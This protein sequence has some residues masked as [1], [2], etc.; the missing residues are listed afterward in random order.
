M[1]ES[2]P[3]ALVDSFLPEG[4]PTQVLVRAPGKVNLALRVGPLGD[5]GYHELA[6]VFLALDLVDEL[7]AE[8]A[9]DLS[10]HLA[11]DEAREDVPLDDTNLAYRAA[12]LLRER[13]GIT[14][15][16]RLTITK[17]IPVAGGMGGGSADAAAALIACDALWGLDTPWDEL[18]ELAA[19]LG[20]D[21]PFSL[22]GGAAIG[23]GHGDELDAIP[24]P[25]DFHFV[26]V[27]SEEGLSTPKCYRALDLLRAEGALPEA[28][29]PLTISDELLAALAQG[30]AVGLAA[31]LTNDLEA[32]AL[33]IRPDLA[34]TIHAGA[35]AGAIGGIVSGSGPTIALLAG[36]RAAAEEIAKTLAAEGQRVHVASGPARG[37][38]LV[39]EHELNVRDGG[40]R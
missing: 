17:R 26:L 5:D 40:I 27:T 22:Q 19:E 18:L 12:V 14:A 35:L 36:S 2:R 28:A 34:E 16:A 38:H 31:E 11:H 33:V 37:A 23:R 20:A 4:T 15:G 7:H 3:P 24:A 6:T 10:V 25:H 21:V 8:L 30:D 9:D 13:A 39:D 32:A 29:L 1:S